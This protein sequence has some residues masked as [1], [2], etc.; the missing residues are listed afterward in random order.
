MIFSEASIFVVMSFLIEMSFEIRSSDESGITEVD[1][2]FCLSKS[3]LVAL[4][5]MNRAEY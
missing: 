3:T 4:A 5:G 2:K 1:S